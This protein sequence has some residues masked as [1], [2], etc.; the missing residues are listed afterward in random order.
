MMD[1][2]WIGWISSVQKFEFSTFRLQF[3]EIR[4]LYKYC[5]ALM[6]ESTEIKYLR[7]PTF[8]KWRNTINAH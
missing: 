3:Y 2:G 6:D 5:N 8:V 4:I 1:I 7:F